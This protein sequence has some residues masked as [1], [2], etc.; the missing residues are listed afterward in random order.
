MQW[1]RTGLNVITS[2]QG[3]KITKSQDEQ[4]TYYHAWMPKKEG[5][6]APKLIGVFND[7][8]KAKSACEPIEH[9]TNLEQ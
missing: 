6:F 7:V 5:E 2:D 8:E 4:T 9:T 1:K 3:H